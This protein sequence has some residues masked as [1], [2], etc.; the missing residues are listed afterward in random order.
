MSCDEIQLALSV[1][2]DDVLTPSVKVACDDHLQRCPVC[3]A[4]L[5]DL[6]SL[7]R[8]LARLAP[9]PP[10]ADLAGVISCALAIEAG[11]RVP[12][13]SIGS[14][15]ADWLRPR[16][17]PYAISSFASVVLFIGMFVGLRPHFVALRE[18]QEA[19]EAFQN[20]AGPAFYD[21][22]QPII[23]SESYAALRAPFSGESP[24]LNPRGALAAMT[25]SAMHIHDGNRTESDDMIVVA[26]VYANGSASLA[27]VVYPPR[28]SRMLDEFQAALRQNAAFVPASLDGRP[29]TMRVVFSVQKVDVPER[30]F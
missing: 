29:T 27:G 21:I 7:T 17:V 23:S 16:M 8:S 22:N 18:A 10:A 9:P 24:S 11:A 1:Y 12:A 6:R 28:D 25:R 13:R 5:A 2:D 26:D 19:N 30:N 3:R 15:L 20:A 14:Q 4:E